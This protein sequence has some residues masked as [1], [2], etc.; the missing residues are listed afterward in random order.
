MLL[1]LKNSSMKN[2]DIEMWRYANELKKADTN[3]ELAFSHI[4]SSSAL[5]Q[6]VEIRTNEWGL[7]GGPIN[8]IARDERRI[9]MIGGS[10]TLG[11][12]VPE[13]KTL[14]VLLQNK[15]RESGDNVTVLNAGIGNYNAERYVS[16]FFAE[17]TELKPTDIVVQYFLRDAEDLSPGGGNWLLRHSQLAVT[18]WIAYHRF[19]ENSGENLLLEHYR[20]V[21]KEEKLGFKK[22]KQKLNELSI[23][24]KQND[25]RIYLAM[26]PDVHNLVNY[27]FEFIH[28]IIKDIAKE[29][30]YK[31]I[32][33]LPSFR[34]LTPED[35]YAMPGDPHP[36]AYGHKLMAEDL[37]TILKINQD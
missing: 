33:F 1:R 32:D 20:D 24:A 4:K 28:D 10:I 16:R 26:T 19:F 13:D 37:L 21:Y 23:Y 2:Y 3:P 22:M 35:L 27:Q 5:L 30:D 7:R 31:F 6:G 11:W 18:L 12:G 8:P 29:N 17:H 36:N 15:L 14:T 25:I 34:G 9:L